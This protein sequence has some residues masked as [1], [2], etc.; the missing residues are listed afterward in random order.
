[1]KKNISLAETKNSEYLLRPLFVEKQMDIYI[2][3]R[4][5]K[6]IMYKKYQ[7]LETRGP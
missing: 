1:V 3:N 7:I 4:V 2:Q 5:T 6:I